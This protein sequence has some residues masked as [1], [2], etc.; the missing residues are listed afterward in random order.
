MG[1]NNLPDN[2]KREER[3]AIMVKSSDTNIGDDRLVTLEAT[4]KNGWKRL[5]KDPRR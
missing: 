5:P 3:H 2:P 1:K 4:G